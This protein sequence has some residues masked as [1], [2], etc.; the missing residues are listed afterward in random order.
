MNSSQRKFLV[1]KITEKTR[2]RIKELEATIPNTFNISIFMLHK[3][4][5]GDFQIKSNEELREVIIRKALS[6]GDS[7][8]NTDS[9]TGDRWDSKTKNKVV[10]PISD[11]FVIPEE[12]AAKV[13]EKNEI[14]SRVREEVRVL[15]MHL[16]NLEVRIMVASDKT[17]QGLIKD[18]DDMGDIRLI[19][20]KIKLLT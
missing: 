20:T 8:R 5:S 16:E 13:A 3:V 17:L 11:F 19:D 18:I 4:L 6:T 15:Q 12:Y 7:D 14:E 1:D 9:W 10:I 2:N